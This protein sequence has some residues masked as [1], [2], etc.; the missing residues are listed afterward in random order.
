MTSWSELIRDGQDWEPDPELD[1]TAIVRRDENGRVEIV[2]V[3][4]WQ[5]AY[6]P[7]PPSQGWWVLEN[8]RPVD[9]DDNGRIEI[10]GT[11]RTA[12]VEDCDAIDAPFDFRRLPPSTDVYVRRDDSWHVVG[13]GQIES[14]EDGAT[15]IID[16]LNFED[17]REEFRGAIPK[18]GV[19]D[20]RF[21]STRTSPTI[22]VNDIRVASEGQLM[23]LSRTDQTRGMELSV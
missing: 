3:S 2:Y 15:L 18:D 10:T 19:H 6:V 4:D 23:E 5:D 8:I 16:D 13:R 22:R 9:I 21:A 11:Y 14:R 12:T 1:T 17:G 20:L 7:T